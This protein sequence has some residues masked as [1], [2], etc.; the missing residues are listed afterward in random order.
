M[1]NIKAIFMTSVNIFL[2]AFSS[3]SSAAASQRHGVKHL[4]KYKN[5]QNEFHSFSKRVISR[6]CM[7]IS[8]TKR[9]WQA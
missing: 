4:K 3:G 5:V 2:V 9:Y 8:F 6:A 7:S 1:T